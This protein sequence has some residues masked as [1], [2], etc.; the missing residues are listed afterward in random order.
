MRQD[1]RKNLPIQFV[2]EA[3]TN[4]L[5]SLGALPIPVPALEALVDTTDELLA[6]ADGLLLAEGGDLAPHVHPTHED[7]L[8]SLKELDVEKDAL[9][10]ALA[11]RAIETGVPTLGTCR[12]AQVLNV[13]SGGS[14]YSDLPAELGTTVTHVDGARYDELR[15]TISLYEGTAVAEI[16]E[17][18]EV[19]VTSVHHQGVRNLA[20]GLVVNAESTDGLIEAFHAPE[21]PFLIGVQHH[22][23]RQFDEH[24]GHL[25]LYRALV[26]AARAFMS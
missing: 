5:I 17:V 24:P 3:H 1:A 20:P 19:H 10:V 25:G 22:P 12:G 18:H 21:H 11:R 16:Y 26:D 2:H 23:E 4:A 8:G 14:L 6:E 7:L 9:E 15:H 13:V